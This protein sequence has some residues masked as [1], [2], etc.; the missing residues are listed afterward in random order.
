MFVVAKKLNKKPSKVIKEDTH[1]NKYHSKF[2]EPHYEDHKAEMSGKMFIVE[3]DI[4]RNQKI[5]PKK[6]F[7]NYKSNKKYAEATKGKTNKKKTKKKKSTTE[8]ITTIKPVPL[9]KV[10]NIKVG[11]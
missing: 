11:F 9:H 7:Q 5:D 1:L 8:R 2:Y 3:K 4:E 6:V 10:G